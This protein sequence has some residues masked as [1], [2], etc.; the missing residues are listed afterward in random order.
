VALRG[1]A[2]GRGHDQRVEA[3]V[4]LEAFKQ[5]TH[6]RM[7]MTQSERIS[8]RVAAHATAAHARTAKH[9]SVLAAQLPECCAFMKNGG[10]PPRARSARDQA[11]WVEVEAVADAQCECAL[12]SGGVWNCEPQPRPTAAAPFSL[13][14]SAF[15]CDSGVLLANKN[16][17]A[18]RTVVAQETGQGVGTNCN[19]VRCHTGTTGYSRSAKSRTLHSLSQI[20]ERSWRVL[21]PSARGPMNP[22]LTG[23]TALSTPRA[24]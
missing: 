6:S 15:V 14:L 7:H 8:I 2:T 1:V 22:R 5:H 11:A 24:G 12:T 17:S 20:D 9:R 13:L 18:T 16:F 4:G 10:T 23:D 19:T 21:V 3:V